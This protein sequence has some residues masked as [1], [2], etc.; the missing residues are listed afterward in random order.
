MKKLLVLF[1]FLPLISLCQIGNAQ[2]VPM[3]GLYTTIPSIVHTLPLIVRNELLHYDTTVIFKG[4]DTIVHVHDYVGQSGT[5]FEKVTCAV[6]HGINGCPD[7]WEEIICT[8]C[9]RNSKLV[10][11][12]VFAGLN[13]NS[14]YQAAKDRLNK[15][16]K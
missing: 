11:K 16:K 6:L 9:L 1:T 13:T 10:A 4:I 5:S 14:P 3:P 12:S 7:D 2:A 8:V 15:L